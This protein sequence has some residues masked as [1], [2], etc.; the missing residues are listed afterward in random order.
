MGKQAREMAQPL[1]AIATKMSVS[2]ELCH[3]STHTLSP[4]WEEN[5]FHTEAEIPRE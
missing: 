2:E 3:Q 4:C 1:K 5:D